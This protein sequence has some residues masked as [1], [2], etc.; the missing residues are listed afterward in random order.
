M[1]LKKAFEQ[2]ESE[3]PDPTGDEFSEGAKALLEEAHR[4]YDAANNR[5][6]KIDSLHL[7]DRLGKFAENEEVVECKKCL[8]DKVRAEIHKRQNR[9]DVYLRC[10]TCRHLEH[11]TYEAT[12][13]INEAIERY[14]GIQ[15]SG[16]DN[17]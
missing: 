2:Y 7:L 3:N 17:T 10:A 11:E 9:M 12:E 6:Q 1:I 13:E 16:R 4:L 8:S 5:G 14:K 15:I